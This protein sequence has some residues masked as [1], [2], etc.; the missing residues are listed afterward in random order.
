[1]CDNPA[2]ASGGEFCPNEA[3]EELDCN[4]NSCSDYFTGNYDPRYFEKIL[5]YIF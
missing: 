2:P 3:D 4:L 1:M 5:K